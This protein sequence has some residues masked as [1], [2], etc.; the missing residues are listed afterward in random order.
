MFKLLTSIEAKGPPKM[1]KQV[2]QVVSKE[3]Q[4]SVLLLGVIASFYTDE[5]PWRNVRKVWRALLILY[6]AVLET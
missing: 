3:Q 2:L 5:L 4:L 1:L 6:E